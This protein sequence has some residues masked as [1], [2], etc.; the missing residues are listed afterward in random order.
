MLRQLASL[1]GPIP[2]QLCCCV[3]IPGP[4]RLHAIDLTTGHEKNGSPSQILAGAKV[5]PGQEVVTFNASQQ[6]QRPG[7]TLTQ[8]QVYAAFGSRCGA[9]PF[10]P[11]IFAFDAYSIQL[12][13]TYTQ[14]PAGKGS[15]PGIWQ[16]GAGASPTDHHPA[17]PLQVH[18]SPATRVHKYFD[19]YSQG[20]CMH[21]H[22]S[23]GFR[24]GATWGVVCFI[25][26]CPML[27]AGDGNVS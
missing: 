23:R 14:P 10:S 18:A 7:L 8:G 15:G 9:S 11:W 16:A 27:L 21:G 4:C 2:L 12:T 1:S 5:F 22:Q 26:A 20:T 19:P 13:D 6:L 24:H 17:E 25:V 3:L